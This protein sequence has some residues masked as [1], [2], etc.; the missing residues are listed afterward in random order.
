RRIGTDQIESQRVNS[1]TRGYCQS[2]SVALPGVES[3]SMKESDRPRALAVESPIH[4]LRQRI[5]Q[6]H[7]SPSLVIDG[8]LDLVTVLLSGGTRPID[9]HRFHQSRPVFRFGE[10]Q[11]LLEELLDQCQDTGYSRS[12]LAG[13][14][15]VSI[16]GG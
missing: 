11:G 10:V 9:E 14:A 2:A 5:G 8:I 7:H 4:C 6:V 1:P 15:F 3:V 13:A 16:P 12:R